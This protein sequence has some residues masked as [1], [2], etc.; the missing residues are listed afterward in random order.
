MKNVLAVAVLAIGLVTSMA[1]AGDKDTYKLEQKITQLEQELRDLQAAFRQQGA[2]I[3]QKMMAVEQMRADWNGFQ[4]SVDAISQ[5]QQLLFDQLKK[6]ID[7]FDGRL[8]SVEKRS[9]EV[10]PSDTGETE[11]VAARPDT[12]ATTYQQGLNAVQ[13]RD[14]D[15]ALA[16]FR[17]YLRAA[18]QSGMAA[19]AQYWIGECLFAQKNF[20]DAAKEFQALVDRYPG[21][22]KIGAALFKQGLAFAELG[23]K[24]QAAGAYRKVVAQAPN[25]KEARQATTRLRLLEP[26]AATAERGP[27]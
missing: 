6:Y 18:P 12:A 21:S 8:R 19:Q 22:E 23:M 24:P 26:T 3:A 16:S 25:S 1:G 9:A 17:Q 11:T 15:T 27:R 2:E 14:Y 13:E 7:E 4:G 10:T 5:Q 20:Q